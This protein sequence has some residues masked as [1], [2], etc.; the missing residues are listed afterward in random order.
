M[1][2]AGVTTPTTSSTLATLATIC[3]SAAATTFPARASVCGNLEGATGRK[4]FSYKNNIACRRTTSP[5]L[6]FSGRPLGSIVAVDSIVTPSAGLGATTEFYT[7]LR[8]VTAMA[9]TALCSGVHFPNRP[10]V[11]RWI[12]RRGRVVTLYASCIYDF[13]RAG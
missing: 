5:S 11:A 10:Y 7:F 8:V 2:V 4:A 9:F 13:Y 1:A 3:P 6:S 12:G